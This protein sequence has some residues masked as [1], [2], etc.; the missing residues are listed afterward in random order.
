MQTH[1]IENNQ[2]NLDK[3][4]IAIDEEEFGEEDIREFFNIIEQFEKALKTVEERLEMVDVYT[5]CEKKRIEDCN[6]DC[7]QIKGWFGSF[8]ERVL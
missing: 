4:T 6:A 1:H 5:K 2:S 8:V 3:N 7:S